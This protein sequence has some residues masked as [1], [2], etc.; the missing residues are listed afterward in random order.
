MKVI[1]TRAPTHTH[2]LT[3]TR[4][5]QLPCRCGD[6]GP[7]GPATTEG[8]LDRECVCSQLRELMST[9]SCV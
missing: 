4:T 7:S 3:H 9:A 2:G 6:H 1:F 8:W 5:L